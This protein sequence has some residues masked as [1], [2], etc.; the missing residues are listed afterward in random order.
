MLSLCPT[1]IPISHL[2]LV[3]P[4]CSLIVART[5]SHE[6]HEW[7]GQGEE[8]YHVW[9][10]GEEESWRVLVVTVE[11]WLVDCSYSVLS[12]STS[13]ADWAAEAG[14]VPATISLSW[15]VSSHV[16]ASE[17]HHPIIIFLYLWWGQTVG[18]SCHYYH[19]TLN[20]SLTLPNM[21]T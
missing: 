9:V 7:G 18:L 11:C 20:Y 16:E 19:I 5:Q 14:P 13:E 3:L 21:S 17:S 4:D 12:L 8:S 1:N 6:S 2:S 10:R 15:A